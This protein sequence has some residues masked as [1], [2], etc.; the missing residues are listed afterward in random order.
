MILTPMSAAFYAQP[1]A[2]ERRSA[3]I[4]GRRIGQ[5]ED[6]AQAVL[7][8]ASPRSAYITGDEITVDGGYTRNIMSLVPRAGYTADDPA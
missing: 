7:F 5:P 1:G 2:Q 6:I 8:L 4:P 3:V